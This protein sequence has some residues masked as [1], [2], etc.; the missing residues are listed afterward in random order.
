MNKVRYIRPTGVKEKAGVV[1]NVSAAVSA[2]AALAAVII[3][4][5]QAASARDAPKAQALAAQQ[6]SACGDAIRAASANERELHMFLRSY[7]GNAEPIPPERIEKLAVAQEILI[8]T[9]STGEVFFDLADQRAFRRVREVT[10]NPALVASARTQGTIVGFSPEA[11]DELMNS[12]DDAEERLRTM[13][14]A[15]LFPR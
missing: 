13:C 12:V 3:A 7:A 11:V 6:V 10:L 1:A 15:K 4:G 5:Q 9:L 14:R 2:I 8:N